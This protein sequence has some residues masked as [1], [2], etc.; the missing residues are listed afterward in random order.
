M[1]CQRSEKDGHEP[2]RAGT[3][4]GRPA[5]DAKSSPK[6]LT[7]ILGR[8]Q[9]SPYGL[10]LVHGGAALVFIAFMRVRS[11]LRIGSQPISNVPAAPIDYLYFSIGTLTAGYGDMHPQTHYGHL[12]AT[13]GCSRALSM[14]LMTGLTLPASHGQTPGC[15]L[16]TTRSFL[17]RGRADPDD[18]LANERHNIIGNAGTRLWLFR[19]GAWKVRGFEGSMSGHCCETRALRLR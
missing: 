11:V 17:P 8:H 13:V 7:S 4:V 10:Q 3:E 2:E 18:W 9:P 14:S 16:R 12:I 1:P 5:A 15:C 6:A 19:N